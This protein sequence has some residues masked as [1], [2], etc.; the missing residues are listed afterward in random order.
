MSI[1]AASRRRWRPGPTGVPVWGWV[2]GIAAVA[3]ILGYLL[4]LFVFRGAG[5]DVVAVPDLRQR[6]VEQARRTLSNLGLR[7]EEGP[8]LAHPEIPA[9]SVITQSPLPGQEVAPGSHVRVNL[10]SGAERMSVPDVA[11]RSLEQATAMLERVG[12]EVR[13]DEQESM[14]RQG[15]IIAMVPD[16]GTQVALGAVVTLVVSAG[17]PLVEVP[18]LVGY[19]RDDAEARLGGAGL[20]AGAIDFDSFSPQPSGRVLAQRPAAGDSLRAGS[21]VGLTVAGSPPLFG[22]DDDDS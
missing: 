6:P 15:Q 21:A 14:R 1:G 8:A 11:N 9:G 10:S 16:A 5:A 18:N 20:R 19:D 12:F 22:P 7:L 4:A 3:F 17:P 13:V 2:L